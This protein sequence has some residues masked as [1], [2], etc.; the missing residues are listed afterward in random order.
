[1]LALADKLRRMFDYNYPAVRD[2]H[3]FPVWAVGE[4]LEFGGDFNKYITSKSLQKQ[5]G[6][7]FRHFLR[8]IL[9]LAE[10]ASLT[11]PETEESQWRGDLQ[12]ISNLLAESCRRV[13]PT[14]TEKT[15][16]QAQAEEAEFG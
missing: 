2:I 11:P 13:D 10:F 5:E 14:S 3:T 16:E 1:M 8:M 7:L 12:E 4:L 9:L 15:L 6:L